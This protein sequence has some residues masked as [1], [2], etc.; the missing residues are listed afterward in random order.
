MSILKYCFLT[1]LSALLID[2][3]GGSQRPYYPPINR[4]PPQ[5]QQSGHCFSVLMDLANPGHYEIFLSEAPQLFC[6]KTGGNWWVNKRVYGGTS[7]CK[8][9]TASPVVELTFDL[10]FTKVQRLQITPR[11]S[12]GFFSG[13][14]GVPNIPII[15]SA[16]AVI[17]PQNRN[18][19]WSARIPPANSLTSGTVELY[20]RHCDF[21]KNRDMSI[22]IKYRD[23]E[24]G[25]FKINPKNTTSQCLSSTESPSHDAYSR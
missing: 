13:N 19:G 24:I 25:S 3:D 15:F 22:Q 7:A 18:K 16:N 9:W 12:G 11:G 4:T 8:N 6:G 1:L 17:N 20:C 5:Q 2:C 21:D 10:Q 23:Q 14:Q